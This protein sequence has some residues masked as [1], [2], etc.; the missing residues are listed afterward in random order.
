MTLTPRSFTIWVKPILTW[1]RKRGKS[2]LKT[3]RK[4]GNTCRC[5]LYRTKTKTMWTT[6][7]TKTTLWSL[8]SVPPRLRHSN[9]SHLSK[10]QSST[11]A[12]PCTR[13]RLRTSSTH[14]LQLAPMV[15]NLSLQ[16]TTSQW[17]LS[18][19]FS[20]FSQA[21]LLIPQHLLVVGL[22]KTLCKDSFLLLRRREAKVETQTSQQGHS[23]LQGMRSTTRR[24]KT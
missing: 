23:T 21:N 18:R 2:N 7:S 11:R 20:T 14:Q 10:F 1:A 16:L 4:Y 24:Q 5:W 12:H 13:L 15:L 22:R 17:L 8:I 6:T 9:N 3:T 19:T